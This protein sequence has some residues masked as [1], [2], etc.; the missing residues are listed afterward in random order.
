VEKMDF[1]QDL[2]QLS[3]QVTQIKKREPRERL[4]LLK[5]GV[6]SAEKKQGPTSF[7]TPATPR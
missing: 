1:G 6:T 5:K 3:Y 2:Y 7:A 4:S